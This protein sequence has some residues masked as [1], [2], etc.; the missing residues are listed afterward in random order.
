[1]QLVDELSMIYST[2][3]M[4][5]ATFAYGRSDLVKILLGCFSAGLALF[6]TLY[7]HYLQDPS[8][9]QNAYALLT[10]VVFFRSVYVMEVTIRPYFRKRHVDQQN[11]SASPRTTQ[12]EKL[13]R[14]HRDSAILKTM[15]TMIPYGLSIFLGG[16]GIWILDNKYCSQLR[17]WRH[18]LGLPWGILLEGQ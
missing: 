1:M 4:F 15:W 17:V 14:D 13:R 6:I 18:D 7:Y 5:W 8:F 12:A 10:A 2:C 9:H 3:V 16:F 11:G